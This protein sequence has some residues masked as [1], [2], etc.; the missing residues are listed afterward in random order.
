MYQELS[1][2]K[3]NI[4][5]TTAKKKTTQM[6]MKKKK[7]QKWKKNYKQLQ[8]IDHSKLDWT[9]RS[10]VCAHTKYVKLFW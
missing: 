9:D 8:T 1:N 7:K 6:K 10:L 2:K 3:E 4:I 5:K